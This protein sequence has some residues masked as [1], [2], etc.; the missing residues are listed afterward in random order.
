[1]NTLSL[2]LNEIARHPVLQPW[3]E[4]ALAKRC[5]RGDEQA[6]QKL[7]EANLRLVAAIAKT[8]RGVDVPLLDLIQEG[9]IGL[10][11]AV[12]KFDWRR[13]VRFA[14]YAGYWIRESIERSIA[15]QSEPMRI[16]VRVRQRLRA[17]ARLSLQLEA[18]LGRRPTIAELAEAADSSRE[19][20]ESLHDLLRDYQ[21]LDAAAGD[22]EALVGDF[23]A[24]GE[25][26]L[27]FEAADSEL[28]AAWVRGLVERLPAL[29]RRIIEL[30][31][32]LDGEPRSI[33]AIADTV[34]TPEV[35]VRTL[36]TRALSRLR[37]DGG[38]ELASLRPLRR[39]EKQPAIM[40][41]AYA[42]AR[43]AA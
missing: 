14:T 23:V 30:R 25:A 5:E 26:T 9:A 28:T 33:E 43:L 27:E 16:P 37:Q 35:T 13:G 22:G 6:K 36:E 29:E 4:M 18:E 19:E 41:S 12:D 7:T 17:F 3:E 11:R 40:P 21:S 31:F 34:G 10:M 8:Y 24:D 38:S 32:G 39:T 15:A 2:Y 1:M 42:E 20:I